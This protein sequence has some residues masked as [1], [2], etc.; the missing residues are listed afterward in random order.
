MELIPVVKFN[1]KV[2][3]LKKIITERS[4][5]DLPRLDKS[6]KSILKLGLHNG[7]LTTI[8]KRMQ[9]LWIYSFYLNNDIEMAKQDMFNYS[10]FCEYKNNNSVFQFFPKELIS[11]IL[12]SDSRNAID[13]FKN[14]DISDSNMNIPSS[15]S[16]I[17]YYLKGDDTNMSN[18]KVAFDQN[19]LVKYPKSKALQCDSNFMKGILENK[20]D[21]IN[22]SILELISNEVHNERYNRYKPFPADFISYSATTYLKLAW[23]SGNEIEIKSD[24]IPFEF[25]PIEPLVKYSINYFFLPG[26]EGIKPD[27]FTIQF[28]EKNKPKYNS[29]ERLTKNMKNDGLVI[30]DNIKYIKVIQDDGSF[31]FT[32]TKNLDLDNY[33][34]LNFES[35]YV[36]KKI[37]NEFVWDKI[38]YN[39]KQSAYADYLKKNHN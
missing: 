31:I 12:L 6:I 8:P 27:G 14:W 20:K 33:L 18:T 25:I 34:K 2:K 13:N 23:I 29:W 19:I 11:E 39:S 35:E 7:H 1:Y 26:Y 9:N 37:P 3:R 24:L 5:I 10:I 36:L 15:S 17:Y 21:L 32:D 38:K 4:T 22:S 28:S 30:D 16:F